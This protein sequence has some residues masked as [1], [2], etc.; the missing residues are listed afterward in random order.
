LLT[1]KEVIPAISVSP[2]LLYRNIYGGGEDTFIFES[3]SPNLPNSRFSFIGSFRNSKFKYRG[4]EIYA[5]EEGKKG[6]IDIDP[7]EYL[8][9]RYN[10]Y[11]PAYNHP[12]PPPFQ[13]GLV[14]YFGYE[15]L[16]PQLSKKKGG[17]IDTPDLY[18]GL[19][20]E[21]IAIDHQTGSLHIY[22]L[23]TSEEK[24]SRG[25]ELA[26]AITN[27]R[28]EAPVVYRAD[29]LT[30]SVDKDRFV[31]MVKRC[32]EYIKDGDIYQANISQ[33]FMADFEGDPLGLYL[34]LR[35]IN[36]SPFQGYINFGD[37]QL[38]SS[39]PERLIKIEGNMLETRPIAGTRPR[40]SNKDEDKKL[41]RELLLN[42]KEAAEHLMLVDLERNDLGR[43]SEYGS[44]KVKEFMALEGYSEVWHIVSKVIGQRREGIGLAETI[45]AIFP[46]GTITG[47]PKI[48]CME[49]I[50]ELEPVKRGFYTG[51]MGYLGW[52]GKAD[53][54]ILI[55]SAA[56]LSN[57]IYFYAGAG[58]VADSDP[59]AE[60]Y[61][62][63]DKA[64]ALLKALRLD[65]TGLD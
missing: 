57:K 29:T 45:R 50:D 56:I 3:G 38:I 34:T 12:S 61:E 1:Y 51:S 54:N 4:G 7:L 65:N 23:G 60:Y 31:E 39:S 27:I 25:E 17:D 59:I 37:M 41:S 14:G 15:L 52:N 42:K 49:I 11:L 20:D 30:S 58:I 43:I 21:V 44:V 32:K 47:C 62:T 8:E 16:N 22:I 40:S 53:F 10:S 26:S 2:S 9:D 18:F 48:R 5:H 19:A 24:T 6:V 13:G 55:R 63:L 46:G 36:P 35:K 28:Q 64:K 33:R